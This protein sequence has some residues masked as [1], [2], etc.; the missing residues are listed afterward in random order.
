M[1]HDQAD[2]ERLPADVEMDETD[3]NLR[4]Y[5][6]RMSDERLSEY[7]PAWSDQQVLEWDGNFTCEGSLFLVCSERDIEIDEFRQVLEE[8][9]GLRGLKPGKK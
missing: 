3:V 7:D 5:F 6:S 2:Y 8:H 1:T 9:I 4:S